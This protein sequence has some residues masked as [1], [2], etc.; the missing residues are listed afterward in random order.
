MASETDRIRQFR[1]SQPL[2]CK[3]LWKNRTMVDTAYD[4]ARME[5]IGHAFMG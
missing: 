3:W 2:S 4:P 1:G 5:A